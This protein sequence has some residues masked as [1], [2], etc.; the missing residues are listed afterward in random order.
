MRKLLLADADSI[1]SDVLETALE[2]EGYNVVRVQSAEEWNQIAHRK[3][4]HLILMDE[5]FLGISK[6]LF[7]LSKESFKAFEHTPMIVMTEYP[8]L[9]ERGYKFPKKARF[10]LKPFHADEMFG[11]IRQIFFEEA[12]A[13]A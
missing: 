4:F 5:S 11:Q 2:G 12:V 6:H 1:N 13:V 3:S 9:V 10:L 8:E 7:S